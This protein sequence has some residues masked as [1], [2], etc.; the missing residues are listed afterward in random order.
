MNRRQFLKGGLLGGTAVVL[1]PAL[2]KAAALN[3]LAPAT[4][5]ALKPLLEPLPP[6][7]RFNKWESVLL[8]KRTEKLKCL[9]KWNK[10]FGK[11]WYGLTEDNAMELA[12]V[13]EKSG[14]PKKKSNWS[15]CMM[16]VNCLGARMKEKLKNF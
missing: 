1:A 6:K 11:Y 12:T 9:E 2:L 15:E 16:K 14:P 5:V 4:R 8:R 10:I 7:V 13:L 3:K